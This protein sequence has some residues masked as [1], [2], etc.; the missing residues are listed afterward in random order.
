M[1]IALGSI[2][3]EINLGFLEKVLRFLKKFQKCL[4]FVKLLLSKVLKGF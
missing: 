4:G 2:A 3:L 1:S